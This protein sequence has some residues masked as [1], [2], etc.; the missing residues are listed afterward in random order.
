MVQLRDLCKIKMPR[1]G[2]HWGRGGGVRLAGAN[3]ERNEMFKK[4]EIKTEN[5]Q[6]KNSMK[7]SK[8]VTL[9]PK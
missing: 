6:Y 2:V 5:T 3:S 7:S 1:W 8:L 4:S 9:T